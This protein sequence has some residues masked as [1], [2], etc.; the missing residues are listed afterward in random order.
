MS[1][2]KKALEKAKTDDKEKVLDAMGD[3][4]LVVGNGPVTLRASDHHMV[5]NILIAEVK[6]GEL[7]MTKDI[8]AVAPPDQ[9]SGRKNA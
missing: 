3:Q 2:L 6:N 9:C 1:R 5:L 8:G 7:I 4:T